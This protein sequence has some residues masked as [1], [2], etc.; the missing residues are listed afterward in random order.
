MRAYI[1]KSGEYEVALVSDRTGETSVPVSVAVGDAETT[2][3]F[4]YTVE[5]GAVTINGPKTGREYVYIPDYIDGFP[6]TKIAD[7]AFSGYGQRVAHMRLRLPLTLKEIGAYAFYECSSLEK[8]ELPDGLEKIGSYAFGRCLSLSCVD[9]PDSVTSLATYA[10]YYVRGPRYVRFGGGVKSVPGYVN[11]MGVSNRCFI[12]NE[13]VKTI[14]SGISSIAKLVERVYVPRSV[15]TIS[16]SFIGNMLGTVRMYGYP[17]S[18]AETFANGNAKFEF[19]PLAAPVI[20]GVEEGKTYDLFEDDVSASWDDGHVA[21]LNGEQYY[22]GRPIT[23]TGEYTLKVVNGY[24][25]F[26]TEVH[27]TVTDSAPA[28]GDF[29]GDGEV[30]V[31]DALRALRAAA[32]L[33]ECDKKSFYAGDVDGDGEITVSDALAILRASLGLIRL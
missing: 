25:E 24:D 12:F 7:Y 10:F 33:L 32:K 9:I 5:N 22:A 26:T 2:R 4:N 18:A 1:E 15:T 11:Y 20:S 13:G 30:T 29:D 8:L 27:F 21:Y 23:K 28:K 14:S 31:S 3:D 6:V 16:T 17:G 19:V